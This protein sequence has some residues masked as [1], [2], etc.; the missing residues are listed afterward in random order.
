MAEYTV[1]HTG[2]RPELQGL[3]DGPVWGV[4]EPLDVANF[5]RDSSDHRPET[6]AKLLYDGD[7]IYGI[8]KVCDQYVRSRETEFQGEVW[9]DSCVEFFFQPDGADGYF[10]FEFNCGGAL[11][12][13]YNRIDAP[14]AEPPASSLSP[15]DGCAIGIYHSLPP[16][17][18][19][20][21]EEE[22]L[23][24]L[25]FS[26]PFSV[27][28]KHAGEVRCVGGW[29]WRAN[30]F[31]CAEANSHPHW[32]SWSAVTEGDIPNFHQ[33]ECFG[34]IRFAEQTQ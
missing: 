16:V 34:T 1:R 33:P 27:L 2:V 25:E 23:W 12:A 21:R 13:H 24:L 10:N 11:L 15:E 29:A 14:G 5:L 28:S 6:Q 32:A 7:S 4:V 26:I 22:T 31:K 30:F 20:E 8:F 9:F 17:V 19:P 3:W 18:E